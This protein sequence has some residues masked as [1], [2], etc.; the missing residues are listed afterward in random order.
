MLK[1]YPLLLMAL[2][3]IGTV[4]PSCPA[5][6]AAADSM[7][8]QKGMM[9]PQC[10]P[11]M[12]EKMMMGKACGP[13]MRGEPGRGC[14]LRPMCCPGPMRG[15]G[16]P[17]GRPV[18]AVLM[19]GVLMFCL[20]VN[21]LLTLLVALDMTKSRRFNGLWIPLILLIGIPGTFM[22]ALFRIGDNLKPVEERK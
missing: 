6:G 21:I 2:L 15:C 9:E 4:V 13:M 12:H 20:V 14:G 10:G 17:G 7:Q 16:I 1:I 8:P 5:A 18:C 22:Y 3:F 19:F 11:M